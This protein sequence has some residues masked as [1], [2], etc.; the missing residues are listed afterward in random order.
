MVSLV[1]N[2]YKHVGFTENPTDSH[3]HIYT[4]STAVNW[5]CTKLDIQECVTNAK[6]LY[7][8]WMA[9]SSNDTYFPSSVYIGDPVLIFFINLINL[10]CF[11]QLYSLI[12]PN[13]LR[14]ITCTAI[15]NGGQREWDH[16]YEKYKNSTLV[17]EKN[18]LLRAITCSRDPVIIN[19]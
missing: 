8:S 17:N 7:A 12:S 15:A 3:I 18:D 11:N 5:A 9:N 4:R 16:G 13:L 10:P 19:K 2:L 1:T 6:T 14:L